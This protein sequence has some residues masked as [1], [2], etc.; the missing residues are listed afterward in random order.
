MLNRFVTQ[1]LRRFIAVPRDRSSAAP[2]RA[3]PFAV[4]RFMMVLTL[5]AIGLLLLITLH[6]AVGTV[7]LTS[8]EVLSALLNPAADSLHRQV[9][10]NLRFPRA[11]VG[12]LAGGML[13][14]SGAILQSLT[15]NPLA[16]PGLL[17]VSSGGVLA[18][19]LGITWLSAGQGSSLI[20]AGLLLPVLALLGG[21]ITGTLVYAISWQSG[22]DPTR[23]VLTGVLVGGM[24]SAG[25]S[26]L[27]LWA[28][29]YAVQRIIRWTI[30]SLS[31]RVWI[32]WQT[33]WPI[34]LVAVPLG[35]ACARLANILQLGDAVAAGLGVR[36]ERARLLLLG[37]SVLLTAGAVA[38]VGNIG[39][40][41]LIGPHI[42]RRVVGSD[43]RRLFPFSM[44]VTAGLLLVS[45][46]V[47]RTLTI[48]WVGLIT[49]LDVPDT[50]GLPVGA[51]TALLGAPFFFYLLVRTRSS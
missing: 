1:T 32:H 31:G 39:F 13:G 34:A 25:T 2:L 10:W 26:L 33:I 29:E 11:L 16:D 24:C 45:D 23:L 46:I 41:G 5:S 20:D 9:V 21:M 17:G 43:L 44:V 18:I 12:L 6:I 42:A 35:L 36:V 19:V 40:I 27:L 28:D 38:V 48:G 15:R 22:S 14:L 50:A 3:T 30:G 7:S 47:A 49:G 8:G 4:R 37:A 51:V